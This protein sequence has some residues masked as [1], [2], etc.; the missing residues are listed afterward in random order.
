MSEHM[1]TPPMIASRP[2]LYTTVLPIFVYGTLRGGEYNWATLLKGKTQ[3]EQPA[4]APQHTL[5]ADQFPFVA[6]GTGSVVGDLMIVRAELYHAVIKALDTLEEFDPLTGTGWYLRVARV[7]MVG[8][9][10]TLAWIYHGSPAVLSQFTS[11]HHIPE[12][13]WLA[14]RR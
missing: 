7:V 4:V 14:R 6:D 1:K 12:G 13:D 8:N 9:E 2:I 3:Q 5:Y 10:S 11:Q